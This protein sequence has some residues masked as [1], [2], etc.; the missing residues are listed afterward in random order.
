MSKAPITHHSPTTHTAGP[1]HAPSREPES[2]PTHEVIPGPVSDLPKPE[3]D[4][5]KDRPTAGTLPDKF[6]DLTKPEPPDPP[7]P[8][9]GDSEVLI[10]SYQPIS[11]NSPPGII[12]AEAFGDP[13]G[14]TYSLVTG[15]DFHPQG[16][17]EINP[18]TGLINTS[19]HTF[20]TPGTYNITVGYQPPDDLG[21]ASS[22]VTLALVVDE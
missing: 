18:T 6:P 2:K 15:P 1:S 13:P 14:G 9:P 22:E 5:P 12:V 3:P 19:M 10:E 7:I 8:P 20:L 21:L 17:L 16:L 11:A 4:P